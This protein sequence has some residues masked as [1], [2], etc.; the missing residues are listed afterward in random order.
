M[1]FT[2]DRCSAAV[3][4]ESNQKLALQVSLLKQQLG[5]VTADNQRLRVALNAA[6]IARSQLC[7]GLQKVL[8]QA[9][10]DSSMGRRGNAPADRLSSSVAKVLPRQRQANKPQAI[11]GVM[12]PILED[13]QDET[14]NNTLLAGQQLP[15]QPTPQQS[16]TVVRPTVVQPLPNR[17]RKTKHTRTALHQRRSELLAAASTLPSSTDSESDT[18]TLSANSRYPRRTAAPTQGSL[19]ERSCKEKMRRLV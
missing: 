13:T 2:S 8:D 7:Y 12:H 5:H 15:Q 11:V 6:Q 19:R 3:Y 10:A 4:R 14:V 1:V 18:A 16:I 17:V 9:M